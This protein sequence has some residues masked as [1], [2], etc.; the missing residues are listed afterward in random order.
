MSN[1]QAMI[2]II[3]ATSGQANILAIPRPYIEFMGS[4]DGGLFLSQL[5]Y[6]SDKGAHDGGWFYKTYLE[7]EEETTLSKYEISKQ[8]GIL[9]KKGILETKVKK[10]HGAPTVH[11]LF[12]FSE[13]QKSFV[14]FLHYGKLSNLTMESEV[15]LQSITE[16]TTETTTESSKAFSANAD[17]Q[18]LLTDEDVEE[19]EKKIADFTLPIS[20]LSEKEVKKL[21][22]PLSDWKQY[23]EDEQAERGRKGIISYLEKKIATGL[24]LPDNTAAH[25]FF[26]KLAIEARARGHRPAEKFPTMAIKEKFGIAAAS[27]NGTLESAISKALEA[28][29]TSIPK[30]VNYI[31]SPKWSNNES[32][33]NRA[34]D[35]RSPRSN[36]A[37][38]GDFAP[39]PGSGQTPEMARRLHEA[40]APKP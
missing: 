17:G 4:L 2:E 10:A 26:D 39:P 15:T 38:G 36:K 16:T 28:G 1:Q 25:M 5:I 22:L 9:K 32:D 18:F 3:K 19:I 8:A 11:Y 20:L 21:K 6:W 35:K 40:F 27:L 30:I 7:W 13:F 31:S 34:N 14:E 23:L 29:I 33:Q 12:S 37:N 24:L